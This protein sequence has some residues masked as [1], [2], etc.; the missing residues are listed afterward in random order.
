MNMTPSTPSTTPQAVCMK[1]TLQ[2]R[3]ARRILRFPLARLR[4][5]ASFRLHLRL[6]SY[7]RV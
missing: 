7:A 2:V 6:R 3:W 4:S 5:L 1:V